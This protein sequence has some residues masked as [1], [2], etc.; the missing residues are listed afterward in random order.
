MAVI[1]PAGAP[2]AMTQVQTEK[3][4][5]TPVRPARVLIVED[6]RDAA[7]SLL[8]LLSAEGFEVR[9]VYSGC[10]AIAAIDQFDA[11][12]A[13]IDLR[14]LDLNGWEV[15]RR[16]RKARGAQRPL[17]IAMSGQYTRDSQTVLGHLAGFEHFIAKPYEV[18]DVLAALAPIT[19]RRP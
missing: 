4:V 2:P 15:A 7:E 1:Q 3:A 10:E 14:L 19:R 11:D 5:R 9:A 18:G 12:A 16:I 6:N 8:R 17:L 13:L